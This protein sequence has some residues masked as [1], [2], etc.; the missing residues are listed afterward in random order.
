MNIFVL[1]LHRAPALLGTVFLLAGCSALI[2]SYDHTAYQNAT[3]LKAEVLAL[4]Q[5]APGSKT[6]YKEQEKRID[7][8][9]VEVDKAYEYAKGLPTNSVSARQWAIVKER[10]LRDVIELWQEQGTLGKAFVEARSKQLAQ[11]FDYIICLEAN[12]K[13]STTCS[14]AGGN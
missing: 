7:A 1:L 6:S 13:E 11:A 9:V 8:V 5:K 12:K 4:I 10:L 14:N 3:A 2:S